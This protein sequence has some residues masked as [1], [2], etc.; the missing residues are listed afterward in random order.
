[1]FRVHRDVLAAP[2]PVSDLLFLTAAGLVGVH[3]L[4]FAV[5]AVRLGLNTHRLGL[6]CH[7]PRIIARLL[8]IASV[9]ALGGQPVGWER[10]PR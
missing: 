4:T 3:A 1:M 2:G 10:T 7:A 5:A 9:A 8:L 6:L